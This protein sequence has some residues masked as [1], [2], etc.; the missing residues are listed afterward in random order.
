L[1]PNSRSIFSMG[2]IVDSR[3]VRK[4][5]GCAGSEMAGDGPGLIAQINRHSESV[6]NH[7]TKCGTTVCRHCGLD[8]ASGTS[9]FSFHGT[10]PR[11]FLVLVGSYVL[12]IAALLARWRC[13]RRN[14]TFADYPPFARPYKAYTQP[15][16]TER[17]AKYVSEPLTSYRR[18][19]CFDNRLVFHAERLPDKSTLP[20]SSNASSVLSQSSLF[21]WVT[22]LA[23]VVG[24]P[25][26]PSSNFTPVQRKYRSNQRR[27][28]LI[29]C[30]AA[31]F[32]RPSSQPSA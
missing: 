1:V 31:C 15:Q 13:P 27:L 2:I 11:R 4:A 3:A 7:T 9:G 18:G 30:H 17:A 8:T 16:V 29:A 22:T 23:T 5:N 32:L 10:R 12:R 19:V 14:R 6:K 26:S 28:V 25:R 24:Q 20:P 21:R